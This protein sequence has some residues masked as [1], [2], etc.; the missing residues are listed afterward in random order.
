MMQRVDAFYRSRAEG[1]VG[2]AQ[3]TRLFLRLQHALIRNR[4]DVAKDAGLTNGA[5]FALFVLRAYHPDGSLTPSDL[6]EAT[7][8]TSGGV[9]K[10]LHALEE[11]GLATRSRH[12]EDARSTV[13]GLTEAGVALIETIMPVVDAKDRALLLDPLSPEEARELTRLLAKLERLA[14]PP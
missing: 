1:E 13:L 5:M 6:R 8:M 3:L 4:L 7:M 2:A 11:R 9:T 12:P 14:G 10:V